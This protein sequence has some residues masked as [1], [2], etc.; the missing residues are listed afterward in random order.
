MT[1]SE[2]GGTREHNGTVRRGPVA[3]GLYLSAWAS[4]YIGPVIIIVSLGRRMLVLILC[5]LPPPHHHHHTPRRNA[6]SPLSP[7]VHELSTLLDTL[8]CQLR[9]QGGFIQCC[10]G[11]NRCP[12]DNA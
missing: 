11:G 7:V 1:V 6:A 9:S 5:E 3:T 12:P 4:I 10:A 2:Y 8:F